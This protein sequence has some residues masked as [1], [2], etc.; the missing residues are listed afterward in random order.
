VRVDGVKAEDSPV[1]EDRS[2]LNAK[3]L[4]RGEIGSGGGKN[5]AI[6]SEASCK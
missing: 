3:E 5:P 6:I 4:R 2:L 1:G